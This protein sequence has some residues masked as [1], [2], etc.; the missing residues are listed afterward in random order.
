M[1]ELYDSL[2]KKM[3]KELDV[4]YAKLK[5]HVK[6]GNVYQLKTTD[7][8]YIRFK[9]KIL[10]IEK[11]TIILLPDFIIIHGYPKLRRTLMLDTG[12]KKK[13]KAEF[14]VEEKMD[15]YNVRVFKHNSHVDAITRGGIICPYTSQRISEKMCCKD[16]FKDY[17]TYILCGEVVG[18]QNPYQ[19]K[20]YPEAKE[21]NFFT[22]D[23]MN[24]KGG[25]LPISEK[26]DLIKKY[27]LPAVKNFGTFT[28]DDS[29][30]LLKIV[31]ELG[32]SGREG[33]VLKSPNMQTI[34][35]YTANQSTNNDLRYAFKFPYD[36]GQAF[37][38][39]RLVRQAF[40]AY[41]L[42]L[43]EKQLTMEAKELGKALLFP[44]VDTIKKIAQGKR[45]TE[46][47]E[48]VVPSEEF[49]KLFLDHLNHLGVRATI[50]SM[51][52]IDEG[53][54]VKMS[55]H[56]QSTNDSVKAYLKGEFSGD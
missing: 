13:F 56:Y 43:T 17:P 10:G 11:G 45:V 33:I 1:E 39:R 47:F 25:F 5:E 54:L 12:L 9:R 14:Y 23:I 41:E 36:Y 4:D 21:F 46:D 35:K 49:G 34:F 31:R 32:L 40:Q 26:Q 27:N 30:K 22:F 53:V 7:V 42:K 38:F 24:S 2:I 8:E 19:E 18:L 20:S 55:R 3:S 50:N 51:E 52:K 37:M 48:I 29:K 28:V 16:F 6:K 44:M 15:G